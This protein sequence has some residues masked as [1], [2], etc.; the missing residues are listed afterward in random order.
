[1]QLFVAVDNDWKLLII[2]IKRLVL[3]VYKLLDLTPLFAL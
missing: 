3:D 1:M 2:V